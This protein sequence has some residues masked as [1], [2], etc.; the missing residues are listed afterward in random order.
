M[1]VQNKGEWYAATPAIFHCDD[2]LSL[3]VTFGK[4]L[5]NSLDAKISVGI[6]PVAIPGSKLEYFKKDLSVDINGLPAWM[7]NYFEIAKIAQEKGVIKGILLHQGE[8]TPTLNEWPSQ[9]AEIYEDLMKDLSLNP[10]EV[11]LLAGEL[12]PT[13]GGSQWYTPI[14]NSFPETLDNSNVLYHW[15]NGVSRAN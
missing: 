15:T 2:N 9:V 12:L 6:I 3:V 1:T 8:S 7:Q 14:V 10:E 13:F 5:L 4:P 11:P